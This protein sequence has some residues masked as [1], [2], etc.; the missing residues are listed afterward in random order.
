MTLFYR[1]KDLR[2]NLDS[3]SDEQ[4]NLTSKLRIDRFYSRTGNV[5]QLHFHLRA[6]NR[7]KYQSIKTAIFNN[8]IHLINKCLY[9]ISS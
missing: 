4:Q 9:F 2:I 8:I 7:D 5:L 1:H 3:I 6:E